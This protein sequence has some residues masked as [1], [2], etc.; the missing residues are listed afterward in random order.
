MST[1]YPRPALTVDVVTLRYRGGHLELLLIKRKSDPFAGMWALPGGYVDQ[2][3]SPEDAA[4][5]ELAEETLSTRPLFSIGVF[6]APERDPRGWVVSA[7]YMAFAPTDCTAV[8]GD[9]A[10]E[11]DWHPLDTLPKLAFDHEEV[12]SAARARLLE[13]AQT[14]TEPLNLL[15]ATFRTRTARHLY[16]QIIGQPLNARSFKAWLR[17]REAIRRVGPGRF[18]RTPHLDLQLVD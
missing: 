3:E 14:G 6:G 5:R 12:I 15:P 8:A 16:S 10:A 4:L 11:V 18:E 17:R 13:M 9:D 1:E 2:G 7:A